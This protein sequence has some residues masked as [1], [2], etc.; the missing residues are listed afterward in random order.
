M[1]RYSGSSVPR[2]E[3]Q[4]LLHG[5]ARFVADRTAGT[6]HVVFVRAT[7]PYAD[8]LG[9]DTAEA[10]TMP[11]VLGIYT[12]GE[13]DLAGANLPVLTTPNPTFAEAT[14]FCMAEQ[15]MPLLATSRV[16]Y[17]GQPIVA[18]VAT[19]RYR[20][21][22]AAEAV[23]VSYRSLEP[24]TDPEA[25]LRAEPLYEHL[26]DNELARIG[27]QFGDPEEAFQ[28]AHLIVEREYRMGRHG[29]VPLETR[30]AMAGLDRGLGRVTLTTSTQI[31]HLVRNG[32]CT[33]TGW[34]EHEIVVRV[35][36]VGGGF[37]T[38]ANVYAEEIVLAVLARITGCDLAWVEDR[39]EHLTA[40]AQGRDQ[41]H[42]TK[43]AVDEHGHILAWRDEFLV[44]LGAGSLWVAGIVANTAIHAL[45]PYR[46]PAVDVAGSAV[47][48]TKTIVAQYRGAGRPE[49]AFALERTLDA[50]AAELGITGTR[51]RE[52]NLLST[53]DF[54]YHRPIPYRDGV[55]IAY[56][57]KDYRA[58]L[59]AVREL[60]PETEL[61]RIR[62]QYPGRLLGYGVASYLE[63]TA[64]GPYETA[65]LRVLDDGAIELSTG[66]ASAGQGHATVFSQ[67]A[68]DALGLPIGRLRYRP[69]DTER[70]PDGIGTFASR[71][72]VVAGS[73]VHNGA[74]RLLEH[75]RETAAGVL[76]GEVDYAAGVFR[77]ADQQLSFGELFRHTRHDPGLLDVT[78]TYRPQTVTW[79]MG[80]HATVVAIDPRTGMV[81]VL[82]YAV[83]HEGG[84]ELNP[85]LVRGQILGGV[86]QGIG[87]SLFEEYDY[88]PSG[89]PLATTFAA[90]H[91][92]LSTDIPRIEVTHL[93]AET[94]SNPIGAR[95]AGESGTIA[96]YP[97]IAAAVDNA[98]SGRIHTT[99]TPLQASEIHRAL[100]EESPR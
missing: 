79:T 37:G 16:H 30:G 80:V 1:E 10:A 59:E 55:P 36:D 52:L 75:A 83:A 29:A 38:K 66:A 24:V 19:D 45:G 92:P 85:E 58:C 14:G 68:A 2:E 17:V 32:I 5:T 47:L 54:P 82:R 20:G 62:E 98:L 7:E 27:Y 89:Q 63:A 3:D 90:Y 22:D 64:R 76:G 81:T 34:A 23:A 91:L 6:Y 86:A 46:I 31:P 74:L 26:Q 97:A 49:A 50:A 15:R 51:M 70:L 48:T 28:R 39:Q 71:S 21:E 99:H 35:P 84:R 18:V 8:I 12:A 69:V 96:A 9:V 43:L 67:I 57:G 60:L 4:L 56:D 33:V 87:G 25:A 78:E 72:A 40:S 41:W 73:A 93:P 94:P 77:R 44:D 65:R 53:G 95:G 100:R 42:R 88:A 61:D 11:G 13:L